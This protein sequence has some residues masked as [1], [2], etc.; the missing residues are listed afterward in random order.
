MAARKSTQWLGG[1][2]GPHDY[3]KNTLVWYSERQQCVVNYGENISRR[4]ECLI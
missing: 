3:F 4:I 1:N 2:D